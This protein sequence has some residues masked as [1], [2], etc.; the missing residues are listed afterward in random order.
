VVVRDLFGNLA[1]RT[2]QRAI[3]FRSTGHI[4]KELDHLKL[5]IAAISLAWGHSTRIVVS[6]QQTE[7]RRF[8]IGIAAKPG[9]YGQQEDRRSQRM[10]TFRLDHICTTLYHAGYIVP[11]E[12]DSWTCV[13][14]RTSHTSVRGAICLRPAPFKHVQFI[15]LGVHPLDCSSTL[16]QV[17]YREVNSLFAESAFGTI[18]DDLHVSE[19]ERLRRLKDRRF[20]TDGHTNRQLKGRGKGTDRWP[21]FYI[22]IDARDCDMPVEILKSDEDDTQAAKFSERTLQLI[23]SMTYQFLQEHNFRPKANHKRQRQVTNPPYSAGRPG[24]NSSAVGEYS[25]PSAEGSHQAAGDPTEGSIHVKGFRNKGQA[26]SPGLSPPA[27]FSSWS[28]VKSGKPRALEYLLSGLPRGK[29]PHAWQRSLSEPA[30]CERDNRPPG[31]SRL[32]LEFVTQELSDQDVQLLLQDLSKGSEEESGNYARVDEQKVEV[33]AL[34]A[35]PE[36]SCVLENNHSEDGIIVWKN[37]ISGK[38]MRINTRTGFCLPDLLP[39]P[40]SMPQSASLSSDHVVRRL[41]GVGRP[42]RKQVLAPVQPTLNVEPGSD[43]DTWLSNIL[44]GWQSPVFRLKERHIR[45]VAVD[46][47]EIVN[48]AAH[49]CCHGESN[50]CQKPETAVRDGRLS[51]AALQDARILGQVDKKFI[52]V[53]MG[54]VRPEMV[55]QDCSEYEDLALVIIDQHAADERSRVE[56]LYAEITT[57]NGATTILPKPIIFEV[58]ARE[59]ELFHREKSY[60]ESWRI[61][62]RFDAAKKSMNKLIGSVRPASAPSESAKT[63]LIQS[64]KRPATTDGS[65][66]FG[67]LPSQGVAKHSG[68]QIVVFALPKIIAERCRLDPKLLIDF[69]RSEAWARTEKYN[70]NKASKFHAK[71]ED[72]QEHADSCSPHPWLKTISDCPRGIIELLNSRACRSAIMFNDDLTN[73]ECE[74]VVQRLARCAFPFQCAHGRP[75]MFVLGGLDSGAMQSLKFVEAEIGRTAKKDTGERKT[76]LEAFKDWQ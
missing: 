44:K 18:E 16:S 24:L 72:I 40:I 53:V 66:T 64:D 36:E 43:S 56:Q 49:K 17:L 74:Q 11:S 67:T 6:N 52:L 25:S 71:S 58:T 37:T 63:S 76:F 48:G 73:L 1:V 68:L 57:V 21:M 8:A 34:P 19:E 65:T 69:M 75:S 3:L 32:G 5:Q 15:S 31:K 28:R 9:E 61:M 29:P 10:S 30:S 45:S 50:H 4:E 27:A 59:S 33:V 47:D 54:T 12:F 51:K 26:I 22:R 46:H 35:V 70:S 55:S 20:R 2:K 42:L 38:S 62:Y 60:F 23:K 7:K 39:C 14:A 13:S 41:H